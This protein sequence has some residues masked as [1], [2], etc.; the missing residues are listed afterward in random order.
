MAVKLHSHAKTRSIERGAI[1]EEIIAAVESGEM[2]SARHGRTRFRRNFVYNDLW[3]GKRYATKQ[4]EAIAIREN[5]DWL[6]LTV[7]TRFF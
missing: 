2:C 6:V 7:L 1:E 3:Q 5:Y 4:V